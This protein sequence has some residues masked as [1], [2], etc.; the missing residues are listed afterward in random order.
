MIAK[1]KKN[2]KR[3]RFSTVFFP[4][5]IVVFLVAITGFLVISNLRINQE[6]AKMTEEIKK[7][8]E[9]V[10][11]LAERNEQ[12][13]M[14]IFQTET[15]AYWQAKL[16]EYGYK[17]PGEEVFVVTPPEGEEEETAEKEKSLLDNIKEIFNF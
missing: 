17:K 13:K 10:L 12:L 16:Y 6:R 1:N 11:L 8:E 14:G 7:L 4:I 9:D 3:N 15:D 2:R 5:L